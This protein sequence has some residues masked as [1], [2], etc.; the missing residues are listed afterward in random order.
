MPLLILVA[1]DNA[2]VRNALRHVL[3]AS[4]PWEVIEAEDGKAAIKTAEKRRPDLVILD[5]AMPEVD[6]LQT[7]RELLRLYP[8]LPILLHTLYWSPR[9]ELE[10]LS[11][12][13]RKVLQKSESGTVVAAVRELLE[14]KPPP[15]PDGTPGV[16]VKNQ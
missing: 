7:A 12:G 16:G 11:V 15:G 2:L 9:I 8:D 14:A 4:G 5:L 3:Q 10:A 1:D 6:G 13:I